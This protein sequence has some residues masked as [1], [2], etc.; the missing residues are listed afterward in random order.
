MKFEDTEFYKL[1]EAKS[2][3]VTLNDGS[4][5]KSKSW[6]LKNED[7]LYTEVTPY[8]PA[9]KS[10]LQVMRKRSKTVITSK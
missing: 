6:L 5:K 8:V 2:W 9:K 3:K 7:S 1:F 4:I 10:T